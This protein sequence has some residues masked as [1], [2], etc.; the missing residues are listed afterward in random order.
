M[1]MGGQHHAPA[2]EHPGKT[3]YPLYRRLGG[4]QDRSGLVQKISPHRYRPACSESLYRL[5]YPGLLG[6]R[7]N[8]INSV[9][10][11]AVICVVQ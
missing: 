10:C 3:R 4:P 7:V 1:G 5:C 11:L 8:Y 9:R 6:G 2:A